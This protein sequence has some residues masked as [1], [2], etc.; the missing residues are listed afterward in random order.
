[1]N[2]QLVS[3]RSE[4]WTKAEASSGSTYLTTMPHWGKHQ[5][6]FFPS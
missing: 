4:I 5:G 2:I 3:G 6:F 1:M